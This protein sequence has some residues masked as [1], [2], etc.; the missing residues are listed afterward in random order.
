M[1]Q[2]KKVNLE[3][4]RW[5]DER[6]WGVNPLEAASFE[7]AAPGN[8]HI[9]SMN[10]GATRGNHHHTKTTEWLLICGGP[11]RFAWRSPEDNSIHN[12]IINGDEP[13]LVEIPPAVDHAVINVSEHVIYLLSI[14]DSAERDTVRCTSLFP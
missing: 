6:G 8:L 14:S 10:P 12:E 4:H 2:I 13:L 3:R 5:G 1:R 11:A 7:G 9:V